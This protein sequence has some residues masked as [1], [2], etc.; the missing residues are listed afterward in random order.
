M[1][2]ALAWIGIVAVAWAMLTLLFLAMMFIGEPARGE[3]A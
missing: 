1:T 3:A 2:V